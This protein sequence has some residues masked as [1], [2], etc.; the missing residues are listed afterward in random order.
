MNI[1]VEHKNDGLREVLAKL[2]DE[3]GIQINGDKP[4]DI[5]V[6]N[7]DFITVSYSKVH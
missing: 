1:Y 4:Y 3:A 6:H 2:L 5:Q 7:D